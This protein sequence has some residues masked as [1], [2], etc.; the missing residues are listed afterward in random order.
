MKEPQG[1]TLNVSQFEKISNAQAKSTEFVFVTA[2]EQY[3]GRWFQVALS[4]EDVDVDKDV[5]DL[6]RYRQSATVFVGLHDG[7]FRTFT[8]FAGWSDFAIRYRQGG[9]IPV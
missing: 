8:T 1:S 6:F 7:T 9:G 2:T 5:E 3:G 4:I